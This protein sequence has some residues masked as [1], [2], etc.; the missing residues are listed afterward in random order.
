MIGHVKDLKR[1]VESVN[2]TLPLTTLLSET[3][4]SVSLAFGMQ[5]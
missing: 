2:E 1:K 3:K 4:S 5:S